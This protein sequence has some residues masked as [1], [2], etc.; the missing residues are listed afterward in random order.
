LVKLF[1]K[2]KILNGIFA[3]VYFEF[4]NWNAIVHY[5]ML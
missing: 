1:E 2:I 4:L 5:E 3:I